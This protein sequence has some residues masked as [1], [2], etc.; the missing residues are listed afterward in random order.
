MQVKEFISKEFKIEN[1]YG[2][3]IYY[4]A[5]PVEATEDNDC[6][7]SEYL[8]ADYCKYLD[9]SEEFF[10]IAKIDVKPEYRRKGYGTALV[11]KFFEQANPKTVLLLAGIFDDNLWHNLI[12]KGNGAID[13]YIKESIVPFWL[14]LG[15]TDISECV[16]IT[17]SVA[18]LWPPE[19]AKMIIAKDESKYS[20]TNLF[21]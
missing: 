16:D 12:G 1:D 20:K 14:S 15:F 11:K 17:T 10:E 21:T 18:M 2:T 13:K 7:E 6:C 9:S 8:W 19:K 4:N 5:I 3:L